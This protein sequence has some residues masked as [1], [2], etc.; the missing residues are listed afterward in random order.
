[1]W[2]YNAFDGR[3][4]TSW[5]SAGD[6]INEVLS[7]G[8]IGDQEVTE[9]GLIVG[10]VNKGQ[11]DK[12]KARVRVL[13]VSDSRTKLELTFRDQPELQMQK[14][15]PPLDSP[16]IT[17]RVRSVYQGTERGDPVCISEIRLKNGASSIT[18]EVLGRDIR[19]LSASKQ[20]LLNL[21][22]D[23]PGAPERYLTLGLKGSFLWSYRPNLEGKRATARGTWTG[24]GNWITLTPTRGK[25]GSFRIR[26]Q[27]IADGDRVSR[28]M[29]ITG[30]GVHPNF[31]ATY[32]ALP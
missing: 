26:V 18:G 17:F 15:Q 2:G 12:S 8:F 23:V 31:P 4:N 3:E 6:P 1:M 11:L 24:K 10:A 30:E 16:K 25:A 14:F 13:E 21:W 19:S 5:C 22:L 9:L 20:A 28:Q 32:Q 29:V 27:K 7:I